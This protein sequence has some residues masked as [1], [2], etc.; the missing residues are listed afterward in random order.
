MKELWDALLKDALP[1]KWLRL[2]A[3]AGVTLIAAALAAPEILTKLGVSLPEPYQLAVRIVGTL[4]VLSVVLAVLLIGVIH[5]HWSSRLSSDQF[6]EHRGAFFK[7]TKGGGYS[8]TVYCGSC[9][10]ST[11]TEGPGE[12][13]YEKFVCKCGWKSDF[14]LESLD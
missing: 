10:T 6:V 3:G 2:I 9:K 14:N 5:Q 13:T 7:R 11:T 8:P 4:T 1:T 12:F